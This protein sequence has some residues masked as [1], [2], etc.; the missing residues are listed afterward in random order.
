MKE[1]INSFII[2]IIKEELFIIVII[3]ILGI[4][5]IF[6]QDFILYFSLKEFYFI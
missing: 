6:S 2:I 1:L 5:C 4:D 3:Q